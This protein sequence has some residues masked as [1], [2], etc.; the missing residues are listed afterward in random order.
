MEQLNLFNIHF[1][2]YSITKTYKKIWE[3]MNVTFIQTESGTY[4]LDNKNIPGDTLGKRRLRIKND[5]YKLYRP[6]K[7][8]YTISQL[9]KAKDKIFID[10][11]GIVFK[12]QKTETVPLKYYPVSDVVQA[13]DGECIIYIKNSDWSYKTSCRDA[14]GISYV[15]LLD[16]KYGHILYE[17]TDDK[18]K[19]TRRKI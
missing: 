14:Y 5:I 12:Y 8:F 1:P 18:K 17:F 9:I 10:S 4:M 7:V 6:R 13:E 19:D 2:A 16:T 11:S 15:G 3:E